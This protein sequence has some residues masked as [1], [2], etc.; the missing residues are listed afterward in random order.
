MQ[1]KIPILS[2]V[3]SAFLCAVNNVSA[4]SPST[5]PATRPASIVRVAAIGGINDDGFWKAVADRFEQKTGI[6][7]ETVVTGNK[8]GVAELFK[9]GGIDLITVQSSSTV[10]ALI[11]DG[12]ASDAQPWVRTELIVVGPPTDP[13]GIKGMSDA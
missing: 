9:R 5:S 3:F 6:H 4:E 11:A 2:L 12:Y 13:A 7:V 8:D 10:L 1:K